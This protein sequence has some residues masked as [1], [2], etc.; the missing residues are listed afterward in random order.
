MG[1]L[2]LPCFLP[3]L[4]QTSL[5]VLLRHY[6][7]WLQLVFYDDKPEVS[8]AGAGAVRSEV[9]TV[10]IPLALTIILLC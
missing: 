2:H 3:N 8:V 6:L 4:Q 9:M 1:K 5:L 7:N 10:P